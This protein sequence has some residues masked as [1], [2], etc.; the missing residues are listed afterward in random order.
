MDNLYNGENYFMDMTNWLTI[1]GGSFVQQF[2]Y[3][4]VTIAGL[5]F[6]F[7]NLKKFPRASRT[8]MIGLIILLLT[9]I[10]GMFLPA[11]YT[12]L[13]ISARESARNIGYLTVIVGFFFSLISAAGL[14]L[15]I[16]AVWL[17]RKPE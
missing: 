12:Y 5:I 8:A 10:V 6:S 2:P 3:L 9:H 7:L 1:L 14:G 16:Y 13:A 4:L 15:V 11:I 17:G